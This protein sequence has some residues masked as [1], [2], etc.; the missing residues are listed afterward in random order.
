MDAWRHLARVIEVDPSQMTAA[1]LYEVAL[2]WVDRMRVQKQIRQSVRRK[3]TGHRNQPSRSTARWENAGF[4]FVG[5]AV[6]TTQ[7]WKRVYPE[8]LYQ[9]TA[10]REDDSRTRERTLANNLSW[11]RK[12]TITLLTRHPLKESTRGKMQIR[13]W[14]HDFLAEVLA[15]QGV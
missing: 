2:A 11:L 3:G 12:F 5:G 8:P 14:N 4:G 13:G 15:A 6:H 9:R 7:R 10:F 1:E